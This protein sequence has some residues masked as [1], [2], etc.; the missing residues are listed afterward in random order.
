ME[1]ELP[2]LRNCEICKHENIDQIERDYLTDK[3]TSR[4]ACT[5]LNCRFNTFKT[6]IEKHLKKDVAGILSINAPI[7][8]KQVF[9]KASELIE[10]CD[11]V[12]SM[13]DEVQEE[14]KA[15][16]KP[17]W[18]SAIVKLETVLSGNIERLT[19][20]QGE[21]RESS[22]MKVEQL[23]IQVN[24][25]TQELIEGMCSPCKERLA[26]KML[27]IVKLDEIPSTTKTKNE[28]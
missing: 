10:S 24:N 6:H 27:K 11:R 18:V 16:K 15:K 5:L 26:P 28:V 21:F 7:L 3:I 9:D 13:I 8:A 1:K 25:M 19:K 22:V 14:W 23:N 17:E 2:Q 12:L 4:E 20:I